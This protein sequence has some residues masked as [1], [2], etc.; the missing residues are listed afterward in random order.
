MSQW[1]C[2]VGGQQYGPISIDDLKQWAQQ[3]RLGRADLVW[4]EGMPNW[5]PASSVPDLFAGGAVPVG[6]PAQPVVSAL[7]PHRGTTILV[8]GILGWVCCVI[9][10]IIAWVMG[11]NDLREMEAGRMDRSGEGLT[12][13]G[14]ILGMVQ[15]FVTIAVLIVYAIL[16]VI[17]VTAGTVHHSRF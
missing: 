9:L 12:K 13:A 3:G 4:T 2:N 11:N 6:Y 5:V 14:K 17:G 16:A 15:V 8:L 7:T 1:F 10:G